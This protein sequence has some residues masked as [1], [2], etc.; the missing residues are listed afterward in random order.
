MHTHAAA[1]GVC[2]LIGVVLGALLGAPLAAVLARFM[3]KPYEGE[4]NERLERLKGEVALERDERTSL[5]DRVN[6]QETKR[7]DLLHERRADA[8]SMTYAGLCDLE[9][10]A[11]ALS[12]SLHGLP[13]DPTPLQRWTDVT[14][15]GTA[16]RNAFVKR[17]IL[18]DQSLAEDLLELNRAYVAISKTYVAQYLG[19]VSQFVD[20]QRTPENLRRCEY[21]AIRALLESKSYADALAKIPP[22]KRRIEDAFRELYGVNADGDSSPG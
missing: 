17:Q 21:D 6:A 12:R 5:S 7:F 13:S 11:D 9:D 19:C 10:A 8:M 2:P 3:L 22:L 15:A 4:L 1:T 16:F 20:S 14:E 18:F